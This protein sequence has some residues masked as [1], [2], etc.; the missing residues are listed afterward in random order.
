MGWL[1]VTQAAPSARLWQRWSEHDPDSTRIID[2]RNWNEWLAQFVTAG[3]DGIN[4]V[5]YSRVDPAAR[6]RLRVYLT[7]MTSRQ[8]SRYN[9]AEQRAY[10]INIYNA[11]TID[12][13]LEH[14]PVGSIRD[15][16][17]GFFSI[18]PWREKL[19]TIEG[20]PVTLDDIE[21]RI[22]RPIW[23]DPRLHYALNC[24]SLGCP[25][26]QIEAF[27]AANTESLLD[28]AAREFV[29]HARG[30]Q[31]LDGRLQVSSIYDWFEE[32]FGGND[33]GV[34]AHLK[35]YAEADL[36]AALATVE[37][38]SGHDYD[39]RINGISRQ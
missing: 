16:S 31:L 26:L 23:K 37:H 18:G 20:Q 4:R 36:A 11:L 24:A 5:A 25:N 1:A 19:A 35:Q 33:A 39:W 2:H 22:L 14:Y 30:A 21:H 38:I 13:V 7:D 28:K 6:E 34:I 8:I 32:D 17:S 12:V 3:P 10:W 29:N 27:T 9:R 15:I